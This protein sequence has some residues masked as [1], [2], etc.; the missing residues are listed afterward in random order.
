M[1]LILASSSPRRKQLLLLGGWEFETRPAEIDESPLPA[2]D[3]QEYV[4]RLAHTKARVVSRRAPADALIIAADT[5]VALEGAI[6]GKPVDA[7]EAETMLSSL[8]GRTHQVHT[9]LVVQRASD[10][11]VSSEICTTDVIMRLYSDIE[12]HEYISS[13]DPL[14]KAG[15]YAIQ[16]AG[17]HPVES[18][19]GCYTNVMGL[20]VCSLANLLA[21]FGV[22]PRANIGQGCMEELG[23]RCPVFSP[24]SSGEVSPYEMDPLD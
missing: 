11:T 1:A 18:I 7:A 24:S 5:T 2:E 6:L 4:L 14:D 17:F 22:Y 13:G 21:G 20:P 3:P 10:G 16:H 23:Y 9:A 15:G 19:A 12:M 8:R